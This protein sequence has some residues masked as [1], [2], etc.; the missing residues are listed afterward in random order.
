MSTI[1]IQ[2]I[3]NYVKEFD[4]EYIISFETINDNQD[5]K[6]QALVN[7]NNILQLKINTNKSLSPEITLYNINNKLGDP[8]ISQEMLFDFTYMEFNTKRFEETTYIK[9]WN[10][11][12]KNELK[13]IK[14]YSNMSLCDIS[15]F[16][17]RKKDIESKI[18]LMG[19]QS[20]QM[21]EFDNNNN[22]LI[23]KEN[24]KVFIPQVY[25]IENERHK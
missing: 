12:I 9:Y 15:N 16:E 7:Y 5:I 11:R 10:N 17:E 8:V 13:Y 25:I 24:F 3:L 4:Y 2:D 19:I 23:T 20:N 18:A 6:E 22:I 1:V 21:R 14:S